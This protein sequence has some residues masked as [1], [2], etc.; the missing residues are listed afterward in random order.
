MD[1]CGLCFRFD[2]FA[3][4]PARTVALSTPLVSQTYNLQKPVDFGLFQGPSPAPD[5]QDPIL[6][7]RSSVG[8]FMLSNCGIIVL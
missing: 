7:G 3:V 4:G 6:T 1:L 2:V 5:N 8:V